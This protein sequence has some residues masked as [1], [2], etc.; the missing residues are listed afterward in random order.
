MS[1]QGHAGGMPN[2]NGPNSIGPN[3]IGPNAIGPNA[4]GSEW[5]IREIAPELRERYFAGGHWTDDTLTSHVVR[6]LAANPELEFRVWSHTRPTRHT[7]G[8]LN[9][10]ARGFAAGL[11]ARGIEEGDVV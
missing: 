4:I 6:G 3:A 1:I 7:M 5:E 9:K 11:A 8:D 10:L 2:S